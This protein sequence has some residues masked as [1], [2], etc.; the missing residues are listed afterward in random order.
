MTLNVG[1]LL[2]DDANVLDFAGPLEVYTVAG[3]IYETLAPE[4]APLFE[5]FTL[6]ISGE[7]ICV[8]HGLQILPTYRIQEHP[9]LDVLIIPGGVVDDIMADPELMAWLICQVYLTQ[10]VLAV[11]AGG[12]LLARSGT[13]DGLRIAVSQ[14]TQ[15][16]WQPLYPRV[17]FTVEPRWLEEGKILT[18]A[19]SVPAIEMSLHGLVL[20]A[21]HDLA[22]RVA[23]QLGY[24]WS[25]Q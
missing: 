2:F 8:R 21:G 25:G 15:A 9:P 18:T 1:I 6:S 17:V 4:E 10:Y 20:L 11:G 14:K 13:M 23:W 16:E 22:E 19:C 3:Q 24:P 7:A 5:V 12:R